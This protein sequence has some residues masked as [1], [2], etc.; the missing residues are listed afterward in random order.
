MTYTRGGWEVWRFLEVGDGTVRISNWT[1]KDKV[2]CSGRDGNVWTST[3]GTNLQGDDCEKWEIQRAPPEYDGVIIRSVSHG[4]YLSISSDGHICTKD[5]FA[6]RIS[7]WQLGAGHDQHFFLSSASCHK[8][9][10]ST[11]DGNISSTDNRKSFEVWKLI[12]LEDGCLALRSVEH[13]KYLG[14][15]PEGRIYT[16]GH[17]HAWEKWN[18]EWT[19]SGYTLLVSQEHNRYL[20]H[21]KGH[22]CCTSSSTDDDVSYDADHHDVWNLEPKMPDTITGDKMRNLAIAG[23]LTAVAAPFVVM[24]AIGAIGFTAGGILPNSFAA[25]MMST[26]ALGAGGMIAA[27]GTVATLQSIGAAGLG[28]VGI[29]A[30][31]G[32][33][34]LIGASAVGI[35]V[36]DNDM[37]NKGMETSCP[38]TDEPIKILH[39]RPFC[40]W[41]KWE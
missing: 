18:I 3:F 1:H 7:T 22:V 25:Y 14:S 11:Q 20:S 34:A 28:I 5:V 9:L 12:Q 10:G 4:M 29:S 19:D 24:G 36:P 31:V 26:E 35:V 27:G 41:R 30:S 17:L 2:L 6:G 13:G 37:K 8:Q 32:A 21:P 33:G 23:S 16:T 39:N 38:T 15:T 40:E